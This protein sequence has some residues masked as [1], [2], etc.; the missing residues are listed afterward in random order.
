[1]DVPF[2]TG[3]RNRC[4]AAH[5]KVD[6]N[7]SK[8]DVNKNGEEY[9]CPIRRL[10]P[11]DRD[12]IH[13]VGLQ[14]EDIALA[15]K[16]QNLNFK[17]RNVQASFGT[18]NKNIV[19][20][21]PGQRTIGGKGKKRITPTPIQTSIKASP[22]FSQSDFASP[23]P[24]LSND[25]FK[26]TPYVEADVSLKTEREMLKITKT[27]LSQDTTTKFPNNSAKSLPNQSPETENLQYVIPDPELVTLKDQ[28][29]IFSDIYNLL[30]TQ[31]M[32]PNI[33][34]ELYFLFELITAKVTDKDKPQTDNIFS[35]IHNCVYFAVS[36]LHQQHHV[37]LLLDNAT[38][39]LISKITFLCHFSSELV[40]FLQTSL[41]T[42]SNDVKPLP[43]NYL[44]HFF[45]KD[46]FQADNVVDFA[47]QQHLFNE[48]LQEWQMQ[49][50]HCV[51][52]KF[53]D[54]F[55]RKVRSLINSV[56]S[57]S[58]MYHLAL[59]FEFQLVSRC[60]CL[61][62]N[63]GCD[64]MLNNIQKH[65]PGKFEKLQERFVTPFSTGEPNPPPKFYGV[66]HFFVEFIQHTSSP[67]FNQYLTDVFISK[68]LELN[69]FDLCSFPDSKSTKQI[70]TF[71]VLVLRLLGK[72]LGYVYFLPYRENTILPAN[73]ASY[74]SSFRKH[75]FIP[76]NTLKLLK[77]AI[78]KQRTI[79]T[80]PWIVEFLSMIDTVAKNFEEVQDIFKI[81]YIIYRGSSPI[82]LQNNNH[83][84]LQLI[85]GWLLDVLGYMQNHAT[86]VALLSFLEGDQVKGID[87]EQLVDKELIHACCL[88]LVEFK[89][90][91]YNFV[92]GIKTKNQKVRKIT[93]LTTTKPKHS[94][95][96]TQELES[97]LVEAFSTL[98]ASSLKK[99][100]KTIKFIS[101][102]MVSKVIRKINI[103]L[104][105]IKLKY[106]ENVRQSK[107][108]PAQASKNNPFEQNQQSTGFI[109][110]SLLQS[111]ITFKSKDFI[112]NACY[113]EIKTLMSLLLA[114]DIKCTGDE[115]LEACSKLSLQLVCNKIVDWCDT[116]L[117]I[118][119]IKCDLSSSLKPS[120]KAVENV[121]TIDF[122]N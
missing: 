54:R 105:N 49:S 46:K 107:Q 7:V 69:D 24:K 98:R 76:I 56:S 96:N 48:L 41:L 118:E 97:Q 65:F 32:V 91:I 72:F 22:R 29:L 19:T 11:N 35:S 102:C 51:D 87:S 57:S 38:L 16:N 62:I 15:D 104:K 6:N 58:N 83:L 23:P 26:T 1:M 109:A 81:L 86:R 30:L 67:A 77:V 21:S 34:A 100:V 82:C 108:D 117:S 40:M 61:E 74:H 14:K 5:C 39:T 85:V 31:A 47:R 70:Y 59:F 89:V 27:K 17:T 52:S 8:L 121:G 79:L 95:I 37:L 71:L 90:L 68:I 119:D 101:K 53:Q 116:N 106:A 112:S 43:S 84:F 20:L 94:S 111:L 25:C 50:F 45:Q 63:E 88:Y 18:S 13:E 36:V 73:I 75:R 55:A 12:N 80:V 110:I 78:Q 93:P 122:S 2:R 114:E 28:L 33:V 115:L 3:L 44:P 99:I 92:H 4:A 60:M 103:E 42:I 9:K 120:L 64:E 10:P 66:Q 113:T